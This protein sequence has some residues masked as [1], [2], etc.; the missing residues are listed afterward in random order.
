MKI[1]IYTYVRDGLRQDFHVA[2]MLR[3]HLGLADEIIV[4]DGMSTD[5]TYEV[6]TAIDPKITVFRSDWN[7][8]QGMAF[9]NRFKDEARLRCTGDWCL[10]LDAD[11]F[12]PEWEFEPLRRTLATTDR[13]LLATSFINFYGNYRVYN[14]FPD[15]FR[16][17]TL[18]M[19]IHRN[20]DDI[21]MHGGDASSVSRRGLP[22]SLTEAD[23]AC[24]LHHFGSV[25]QP[26][27]LRE[28]WRNMRGRLYNAPPPRFKL[29]SWLFDLLPHNWADPDFLPYLRVYDGP[30]CQAVRDDPEEFTRDAMQLYTRLSQT[31]P[32]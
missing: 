18:K 29:P 5:G 11:E 1:S 26:A 28:Q 4:H 21:Q 17:P 8:N 27:R 25:R 9:I 12:I 6:I 16:M 24:K 19:N 10:M 23:A 2:A 31:P 15:K 20:L 13:A 3:H 7:A 32:A 22:F 30:Y 14:A